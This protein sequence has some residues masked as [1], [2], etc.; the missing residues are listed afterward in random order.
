VTPGGD[1]ARRESGMKTMLED[2]L[3]K[4][5]AGRTSIHEPLRVTYSIGKR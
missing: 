1:A 4:A 3:S 5:A 2:A